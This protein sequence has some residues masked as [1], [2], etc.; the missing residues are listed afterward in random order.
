MLC[1]TKKNK[2]I[3]GLKITFQ[4]LEC[5]QGLSWWKGRLEISKRA[6]FESVLL[7]TNKDMALQSREMLWTLVWWGASLYLFLGP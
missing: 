5:E 2:I 4:T 3:R 1:H 7:K 6:K